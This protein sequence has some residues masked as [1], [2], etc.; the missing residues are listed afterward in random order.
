MLA[1]GESRISFGDSSA[2]AEGA[3]LREALRDAAKQIEQL[4]C[5]NGW[6]EQQLLLNFY[7]N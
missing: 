2:C 1:F 5:T 3:E 7:R 6:C 4:R